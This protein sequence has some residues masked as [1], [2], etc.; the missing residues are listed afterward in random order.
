MDISSNHQISNEDRLVGCKYL[1][2]KFGIEK[3]S[4]YNM[5]NNPSK[6]NLVIPTIQL[7][8]SRRVLKSSVDKYF[9]S[10]FEK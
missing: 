7:G 8:R 2:E 1:M 5:L 3:S 6:Y 4:A 10:L 9:I